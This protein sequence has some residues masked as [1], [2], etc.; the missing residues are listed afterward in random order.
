MNLQRGGVVV[1]VVFIKPWVTYVQAGLVSH[2]LRMMMSGFCQG[3]IFP[4]VRPPYLCC[5]IELFDSL[6]VISEQYKLSN[7]LPLPQCTNFVF[8]TLFRVIL[9]LGNNHRMANTL[10][11]AKY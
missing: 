11:Q 6:S 4:S 7:V 2:L 8:I 3:C 9:L 10:L 5:I 1:L